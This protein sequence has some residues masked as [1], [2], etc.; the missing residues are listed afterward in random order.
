MSESAVIAAHRAAAPVTWASGRTRS[1]ASGSR[2]EA[3][4]VTFSALGQQAPLEPKRAWDPDGTQEGAA[5]R[6]ASSR[7]F[8]SSK[9]AAAARRRSTSPGRASTRPSGSGGSSTHAR[10]EPEQLVFFGDR[11]DEGGNDYPVTTLG[12]RCIAVDGPDGHARQGRARLRA[13]AQ[14]LSSVGVAEARLA[15]LDATVVQPVSTQSTMPSPSSQAAT[16]YCWS[17]RPVHGPT[18]KAHDSAPRIG[19]TV[20]ATKC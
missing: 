7:C 1:G 9:C 16:T 20:G 12:V 10:L 13:D 15:G 19:S 3:S 4:Q 11:L 18:R 17:S 2:T 5:A 6:C 14:P 8:P